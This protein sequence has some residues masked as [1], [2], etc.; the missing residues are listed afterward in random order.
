M[1]LYDRVKYGIPAGITASL[2]AVSPAMAEGTAQ[3]DVVTAF[4]TAADDIKATV[5]AVAGVAIAILVV[6]Y[7]FKWGKK[8]FN[9]VAS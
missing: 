6:M 7:A 2:F 5:L 3:A 9:R 4:T 8:I 1:N